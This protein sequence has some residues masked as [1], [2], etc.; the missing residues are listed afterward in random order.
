MVCFVVGERP[1]E[2]RDRLCDRA[3][4]FDPGHPDRIAALKAAPN[5]FGS[6]GTNLMSL[7]FTVADSSIV[8]L[9]A[10]ATIVAWAYRRMTSPT[11]GQS[12][13]TM[14]APDHR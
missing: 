10:L 2:D 1:D 4:P 3:R 12:V 8:L 6:V 7:I 5:P 11:L 9:A 13:P 14:I